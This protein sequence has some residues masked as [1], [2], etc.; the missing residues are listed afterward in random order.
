MT[1]Y[2][3]K[4]TK[5]KSGYWCHMWADSDE[6]LHSFAKSIGLK[7]EWVQLHRRLWY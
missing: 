2:V 7:K 1:V 4:L 6:E 5:Y 3:D